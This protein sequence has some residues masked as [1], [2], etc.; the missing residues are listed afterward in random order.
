MPRQK[1]DHGQIQE[2]LSFAKRYTGPHATHLE[3]DTRHTTEEMHRVTADEEYRG[4]ANTIKAYDQTWF[5]WLEFTKADGTGV[6]VTPYTKV[7]DF[8]GALAIQTPSKKK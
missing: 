5:E 7:Y 1:R 8:P 2:L 3:G 4:A 6:Q